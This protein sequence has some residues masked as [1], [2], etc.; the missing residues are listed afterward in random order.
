MLTYPRE[1]ALEPFSRI[2]HDLFG[3]R[4][5][6]LIRVSPIC[7]LSLSPFDPEF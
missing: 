1:I 4:G 2:C 7:C 3:C 5:F 6:P